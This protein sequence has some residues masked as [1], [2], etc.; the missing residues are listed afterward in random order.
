M[1]RRHSLPPPHHDHHHPAPPH[2]HRHLPPP[3]HH[4]VGQQWYSPIPDEDDLQRLEALLGNTDQAQAVFRILTAC[5]P[6][7]GV[8]SS[9]I[10]RLYERLEALESLIIKKE[11]GD[12]TS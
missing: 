5:P 2:H 8:N 11:A 4:G 6:E 1:F 3:P 10:L 12:E 9:L 7:I